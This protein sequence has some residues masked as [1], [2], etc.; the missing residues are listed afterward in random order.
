MIKKKL[1]LILLKMKII[2]YQKMKLMIGNLYEIILQFTVNEKSSIYF[3]IQVTYF[4]SKA[5]RPALIDARY[6]RW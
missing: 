1:L 5:E 2:N 4:F 3:A 6:K